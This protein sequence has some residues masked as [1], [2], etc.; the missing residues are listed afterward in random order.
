M[1]F[2]ELYWMNGSWCSQ[3]EKVYIKIRGEAEIMIDGLTFKDVLDGARHVDGRFLKDM[4]VVFFGEDF[5]VLNGIRG[6]EYERI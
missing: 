5:V 3:N 6:H 1:T 4:P 2:R